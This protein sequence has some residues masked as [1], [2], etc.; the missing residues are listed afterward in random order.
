MPGSLPKNLFALIWSHSGIRQ[1]FLVL[2]SAMIIP[3]GLIPLELQRRIIDDAI[4]Q[5]S[6]SLLL[7]LCAIYL[8]IVI[9]QG[10]LKYAMNMLR[11]RVSEAMARDLRHAV[12][13]ANDARSTNTTAGDSSEEPATG[14]DVTVLTAEVDPV[15]NF[16]GGAYSIP[17][18]EAGT[19]LATF[20]YM[21]IVEPV[22]GAIA[23][24]LFIPQAAIVPVIQSAINRR[25]QQR[26]ETLRELGDNVVDQYGEPDAG[27]EVDRTTRLATLVN[28]L[29][30]IRQMINRIKFRF[31][32]LMNFIDH[33]AV[34]GVLFA[35]G[36][37]VIEGNTQVGTVVAFLSGLQR[38]RAP[39]RDLVAYYR[40]ASDARVKYGL[41]RDIV[42]I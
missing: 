39:W 8:G 7:D 12:L 21:A 35:G 28:R 16:T 41:I 29:F 37:L 15:G 33:L 23:L 11:G 42:K 9:L 38:L 30:F 19:L 1:I 4:E 31:K 22:L 18:V 17:I 25:S 2:L 20:A 6:L 14:A 24:G 34:I 10:G 5:S 40:S 26:I 13:A 36:W 32:F 3:L 27:P